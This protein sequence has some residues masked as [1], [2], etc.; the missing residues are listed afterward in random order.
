MQFSH[1]SSLNHLPSNTDQQKDQSH[2]TPSKL[3]HHGEIHLGQST[4]SFQ[5]SV[6][7]MKSWIL[8][9]LWLKL[10]QSWALSSMLLSMS[11]KHHQ[12]TTLFQTSVS[13]TKS[14]QL[15]L[16]LRLLK[17]LLAAPG[18]QLKTPTASGKSH[19]LIPVSHTLIVLQM[20]LCWEE[21]DTPNKRLILKKLLKLKHK[22]KMLKTPRSSTFLSES[23]PRLKREVIYYLRKNLILH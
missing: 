8:R 9:N 16:T 23:L 13:I 1:F 6:W 17:P 12:E 14:K 5:T 3:V 4:M 11:Q 18:L 19:N 15:N 10:R 7:I 22:R 2:G 20:P 21:T